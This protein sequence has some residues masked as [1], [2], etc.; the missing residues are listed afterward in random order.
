VRVVFAHPGSELY[1]SDRMAVATVAA[2]I[3]AGHSVAVVIPHDGPLRELFAS[4]GATVT[5]ADIPVLRKALLRPAALLGLLARMPRT[6][7]RSRRLLREFDADLVYANTITQPWWL[8]AARLSRRPS[9]VHVRESETEIPVI[10][11]RLLIAPLAFSNLAVS[12]S[13]STRRHVIE[14]G[15]RMRAKSIVIYNAKDWRP[16]FRS[17]FS[18]V[19]E[20][21]HLVFVGRLNPRKGPDLVIRAVGQLVERGIDARLTIVGSVFP[22]YEWYSAELTDLA[23]E[24]GVSDRVEFAGFQ[25]DAAPFFEDAGL[26]VVPSRIEPFGTVAAE[27]MAAERPTIVSNVQGLVEIV[28]D[29]TVGRRFESGDATALASVCEEI[30]RDDVL[31]AS[32]ARAG[33]RS[34]LERFSAESYARDVVEA[35][36]RVAID[37]VKSLSK[38]TSP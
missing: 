11:Q 17:P 4:A 38:G 35:V 31:A 13:E 2:L 28:D 33:R 26:V 30:I 36:E 1:G 25:S 14:R 34:V 8:L 5:V 22:G 7:S 12:N 19:G 32:L 27:G 21:P 20:Q 29:D 18:G 23:S 24:L 15:I 6:L 37:R 10:A 9:I 16:Y 3:D